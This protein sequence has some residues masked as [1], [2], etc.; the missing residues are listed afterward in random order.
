M[1]KT[2]VIGDTEYAYVPEN[3]SSTRKSQISTLIIRL[4]LEFNLFVFEDRFGKPELN[5]LYDKI[6]FEIAPLAS[7]VSYYRKFLPYFWSRTAIEAVKQPVVILGQSK[8]FSWSAMF[9]LAALTPDNLTELLVAFTGFALLGFVGQ[10]S[11][12]MGE[13]EYAH[14][15]KKLAQQRLDSYI[16]AHQ[17]YSTEGVKRL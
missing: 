11:V 10:L 17:L 12:F 5:A 15:N 7:S 3:D 9:F 14:Y 2:L 1:G 6:F 4:K 13:R 16:E 8:Q